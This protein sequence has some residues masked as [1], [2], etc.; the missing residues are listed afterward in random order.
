[1]HILFGARSA[2][3]PNG[4]PAARDPSI[5]QPGRRGGLGDLADLAH[6]SGTDRI[7]RHA[8][9]LA[10]HR[11]GRRRVTSVDK[12]NVLGSYAFWRSVV[13]HVS[14][15]F[16]ELELESVYVDAAA[17]YL[18]QRPAS[19]DVLVAE[20]MFGDILSDLGAATIGGLGLSPSADLGI[21]HGLFQSA[22]GSAPDI[23]GRGSANPHATVLSVAMMLDW[24][25]RRNGD[26]AATR[27]AGWVEEA[28]SRVIASGDGLTADL[29][30]ERST[31]ETSEALLLALDSVAGG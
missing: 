28:V 27:A 3:T 20:N 13:E 23:A 9:E 12:A 6:Q 31:T 5:E 15:D 24:L 14:L 29:G 25:G 8:F 1:M 19:F 18:V 17:L 26:R 4:A 11:A 2:A 30:G 22:H 16:P 7:A 21:D 10:N